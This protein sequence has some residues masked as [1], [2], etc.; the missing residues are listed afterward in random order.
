MAEKT[1]LLITYLLETIPR[2]WSDGTGMWNE[3]EWNTE[4]LSESAT[5]IS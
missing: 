1:S 5:G 2:R 4:A 3:Y